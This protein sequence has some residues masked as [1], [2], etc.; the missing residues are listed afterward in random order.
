MFKSLQ[1][2]AFS[3]AILLSV[4]SHAFTINI[5]SDGAP[6]G[7]GVE[8]RGCSLY[9]EQAFTSSAG[10]TLYSQKRAYSGSRSMEL[11][12]K[13]GGKGFGGLGGIINFE[14][15]SEFGGKV[16]RQGDEIWI[17]TRLLFPEGFE[18]NK[19]GMNKFLRVRVFR[20]EGGRRVSEGYNDL[21]IDSHSY[22][23]NYHPFNF[24][25]EGAQRWF[26]IG[27][28]EHFF[29]PEKWKTIE[30]YLKFDS[31]SKN[32]GGEAVVR[33]W[34]DG[35]L[36][37]ETFDR[38]TMNTPQSYAQ[39]LYFFTYWDNEGAHRTQSFY[40]DDLTITTSTPPQRDE[41]GNPYIGSSQLG[42]EISPPSAP[43]PLD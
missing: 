6:E 13:K 8:N 28:K 35:K 36:V 32:D 16:L 18:F 31:S 20:D 43:R 19:N 12:I 37:G 4:S 24:I 29:E 42:R 21:Y 26:R 14:N 27:S 7:E 5:S 33:V 15:C 1:L 9:G 11:T 38:R 39:A 2:M 22:K 10:N 41:F 40:A 23:T 3:L 30:F 25:F 17:R 34:V